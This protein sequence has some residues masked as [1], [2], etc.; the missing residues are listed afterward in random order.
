MTSTYIRHIPTP[1]LNT[2]VDYFWYFDGPMAYPR[3]KSLPFPS[4][5]LI[6][7]FDGTVQMSSASQN[8]ICSTWAEAWWMGPWSRY[9]LVDWSKHVQQIGISFN[10]GGAYPFLQLPVSE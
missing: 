1:P 2:Y 3:E 5:V 10:P 8:P 4:A 7:N 9:H 6:I